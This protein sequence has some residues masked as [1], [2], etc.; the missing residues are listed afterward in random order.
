M[1]T[2]THRAAALALISTLA[3]A[4]CGGSDDDTLESGP[5]NSSGSSKSDSADAASGSKISGNGYSY[6][7]PEGWA[8]P[9]QKVP[10]TEQTDSFAAN[11]TDT[12]GF[13]DNVNVLRLDPAPITDLDPLEQALF[14][15]LTVAGSQDVTI[16]DR[17]EIAGD[18][19]IHISAKHIQQAG[20]YLTEQYNAI[21]DGVSYVVTFSFSDTVPQDERDKIAGSVLTTWTWS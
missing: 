14:N 9:E 21:H 19:A 8:T 12:D 15:E 4:G 2:L 6:S 7:V 3:L 5:K 13:A 20:T 17:T 10:G 1:R 18:E 11:L 16:Q